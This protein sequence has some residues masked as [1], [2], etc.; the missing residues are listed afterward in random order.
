M[1]VNVARPQWSADETMID[2][3]KNIDVNLY[4]TDN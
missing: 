4:L 2:D 3:F 1:R